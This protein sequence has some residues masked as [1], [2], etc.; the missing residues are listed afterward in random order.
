MTLT[1]PTDAELDA[2]FAEKVAGWRYCGSDSCTR[3]YL[4]ETCAALL[5]VEPKPFREIDSRR[6][7]LARFTS[8]ASSVLPWL[9]KEFVWLAGKSKQG[10]WVNLGGYEDVVADTFPRAA[11]RAL[12]AARGVTVN[13]TK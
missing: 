12:L 9:E 10:H 1:D 3:W 6:R 8:D 4:D 2:A 7:Q 13:F 5:D 11:V